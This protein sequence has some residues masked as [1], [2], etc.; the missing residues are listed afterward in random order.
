MNVNTPNGNLK[1][2]LNFPIKKTIKCILLAVLSLFH[3]DIDKCCFVF[4][5]V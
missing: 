3:L 1:F 4:V 5:Y 2:E